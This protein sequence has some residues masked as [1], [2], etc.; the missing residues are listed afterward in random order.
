MVA[1]ITKRLNNHAI[2]SGDVEVHPSDF[3][4]NLSLNLFQI[5]TTLRLNQ[6]MMMKWTISWNS[7]TQK[8]MKTFWMLKSRCFSLDWC[9]PFIQKFIQ[10]LLFCF[11]NMEERMLQ[12]QTA[13]HTIICFSK[14]RPLQ[15]W[16]METWDMPKELGIF[17]VSFQTVPL[18][19]QWD[20]FIIFQVTLPKSSHKVT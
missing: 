9:L 4:L 11:I 15:N 20:Q 14:P 6:L 3:Q 1:A 7:S 2:D 19:I 17:Y 8:M 5:Q 16:L 18:C 10:Y 12:S 13:C